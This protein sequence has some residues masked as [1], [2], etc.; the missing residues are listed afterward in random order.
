M[1]SYWLKGFAYEH[2]YAWNKVYRRELFDGVRFPKGQVF[3]DVA[4]LPLILTNVKCLKVTNK[5]LYHYTDNEHGITATATG[6]ELKMLLQA[7]LRILPQW[8]DDRYYMHVLNIQLDVCRMTGEQPELKKRHV[9]PFAKGLSTSQ[10]LKAIVINTLGIKV[11]C[12]INKRIRR[13]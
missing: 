7:H 3:E 9:S 12:H 2:C 1:G 10:R 5:G 13:S 11:L 8:Q 4:T 6:Q